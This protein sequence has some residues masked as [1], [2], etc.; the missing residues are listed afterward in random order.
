MLLLPARYHLHRA[1]LTRF[2][3]VEI[4][5]TRPHAGLDMI[6]NTQSLVCWTIRIYQR[7]LL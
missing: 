7:L 2:G 3:Q 4:V 6:S 5:S 1:H